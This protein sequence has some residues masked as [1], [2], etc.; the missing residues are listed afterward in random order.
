MLRPIGI[1]L[2]H[3]RIN[4]RDTHLVTVNVNDGFS[5]FKY[6]LPFRLNDFPSK[7]NVNSGSADNKIKM[8]YLILLNKFINLLTQCNIVIAIAL[9]W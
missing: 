9:N 4:L 3:P 2:W 8:K 6:S 5:T 7:L 1:F